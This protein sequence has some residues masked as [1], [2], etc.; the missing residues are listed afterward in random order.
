MDRQD[1]V[2]DEN[3]AP[4]VEVGRVRGDHEEDHEGHERSGDADGQ[5]VAQGDGHKHLVA[6]GFTRGEGFLQ[7]LC[8]GIVFRRLVFGKGLDVAFRHALGQRELLLYHFMDFLVD[9]GRLGG[10]VG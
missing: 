9:G 10:V 5:D 2:L 3:R 6:N 7:L 4:T 1:D 8:R